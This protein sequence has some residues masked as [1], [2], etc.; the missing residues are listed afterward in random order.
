MATINKDLREQIGERWTQL[1]TL[2]DELKLHTHLAEMDARERVGELEGQ[3]FEEL[4]VAE[5]QAQ[6]QHARLGHLV[7][8]FEELLRQLRSGKPGAHQRPQP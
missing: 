8:A 4:R 1:Q 6:Q 2:R 3:F 5:E 7:T